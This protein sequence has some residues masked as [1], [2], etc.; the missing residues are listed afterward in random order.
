MVDILLIQPPITDFY[1]TAKRTIPYGLASIAAAV[2]EKGF[3]VAI[4]D[5]MATGKS[6]V[7]ATPPELDGLD[8]YY[9]R[10]DH[11]PFSLFHQFRRYGYS[12][13]HIGREIKR[14]GAFLVGIAS[15]FTAYSDM[16]LAVART[17]K[18]SLPDC[19]V[20]L[21]GHHPTALPEAVMA[22]SAVDLVLRGE[23]EASLPALAAA[24]QAGDELDDVP[25][26]V[27]RRPDGGLRISE[28]ALC[29]DPNRLPV[30]A[31]GLI[32]RKFYQRWGRDCL[33]IAATRG[34]P[35]ACSYCATSRHS[36]MGFRKRS[37]AAVLREIRAA[38]QGRRVGFIDFE[39]ENLTMDRRWFLEL[40]GGIREIFG[41]DLPELR[42]MNGLFPPSLNAEV[43]GT[44]AKSGFKTLNLSLGSSIPEQLKR[45]NR[46]DVCKAFDRA[47]ALSSEEGL[48]A[49]GYIIVGAPDQVPLQSVDDL[50]FLA[51]RPVLAGV[52]VFYP[53]PGSVDYLRC[54]ELGLLPKSFAG[55]RSTALPIH[56]RTSRTD[57]AT[58][59]RLGR[60]LNF[61][62]RLRE[63]GLPIPRPAA[64]GERLDP[65]RDRQDVGM[66][67]LAAFLYD[68]GIRGV[69]ADGRVYDHLVSAR[70]CRRFL[71][72]LTSV[73]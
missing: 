58:L 29:S 51:R 36:W 9:G 56:Q 52:S 34:C 71:D 59:L 53:A 18:A 68:G 37:V 2:A 28:P 62:K 55:M 33:A 39:D 65:D 44:M 22:E 50:L 11:S 46:P 24:L 48:S 40:M 12:L 16:A 60:I 10:A 69:E 17:A 35:L 32:R 49:V 45:F 38:A 8:P 31:F 15:L 42:A 3:S 20:V 4:L 57:A 14:S 41:E 67:L 19:T 47:L 66:Q 13:E 21:G 30:P 61:I 54:R 64:L 27:L 63:E 70:L 23:G 7:V 26:I 73:Q 6:R 43:V 72:G 1:H 25:G 5:A